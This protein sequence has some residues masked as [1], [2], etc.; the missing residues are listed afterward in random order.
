MM[1]KDVDIWEKVKLPY[2][3]FN[4][5]KGNVNPG[6]VDVL[7]YVS[8][9][10]G[11]QPGAQPLDGFVLGVRGSQGAGSRV[12]W[13]CVWA[14]GRGNIHPD[15]YMPLEYIDDVF[16]QMEARDL[17]ALMPEQETIQLARALIHGNSA[18]LVEEL[19][20]CRQ[21]LPEFTLPGEPPS[22]YGATG[23]RHLYKIVVRPGY[24]NE[25]EIRKLSGGK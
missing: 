11:W 2:R 1:A 13:A 12:V 3:K 9:N 5:D 4:L 7:K 21:I 22:W 14:T 20:R 18:S 16:L 10:A 25:Q 6:M 24:G 23:G 17:V 8:T 19:R 15:T